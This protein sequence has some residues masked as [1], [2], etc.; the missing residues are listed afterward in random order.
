MVEVE[1]AGYVERASGCNREGDRG[2]GGVG[3]Y[4]KNER[5]VSGSVGALKAIPKRVIIKV[6]T[7]VLD[8]YGVS[9]NGAVCNHRA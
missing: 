3:S 5:C 2:V 9:L 4:S 6:E 7:S 8:R 1:G